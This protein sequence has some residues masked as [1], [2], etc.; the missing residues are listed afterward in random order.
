MLLIRKP[1]EEGRLWVGCRALLQD[2][3][4]VL[5]AEGNRMSPVPGSFVACGLR[6]TDE[7]QEEGSAPSGH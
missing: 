5:G 6:G 1:S 7:F 2:G 4:K 3:E